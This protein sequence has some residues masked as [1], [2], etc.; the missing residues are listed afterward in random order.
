MGI[1][2]SRRS[3]FSFFQNSIGNRFFLQSKSNDMSALLFAKKE[4]IYTEKYLLSKSSKLDQ[5]EN[6][7][8]QITQKI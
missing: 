8:L 2:I 6:Q 1:L 4:K 3:P 5:Q 7:M